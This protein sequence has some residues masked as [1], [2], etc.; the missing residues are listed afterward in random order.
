MTRILAKRDL[1]WPD[2]DRGDIRRAP[3]GWIGEVPYPVAWAAIR[4][5]TATLVGEPPVGDPPVGDHLAA[6]A[7]K[8]VA[9][10]KG[11]KGKGAEAPPDPAQALQEILGQ[12]AAADWGPDGIPDLA[13]L[14]ARLDDA[15]VTTR[16]TEAGR[17][18]ALAAYRA[19]N[20]D[21]FSI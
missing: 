21:L 16:L 18:A 10:G 15:R 12:L 17:D 6:S 1:S 14:Q 3:A 9:K 20:P 4:A 13:L 5:G 2:N 8:A 11:A 19:A 7:G